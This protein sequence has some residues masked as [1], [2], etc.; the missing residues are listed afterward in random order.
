MF[1]FEAIQKTFA[2]LTPEEKSRYSHRGVAFREFLQWM[3]SAQ[4]PG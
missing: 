2:E 3:D 4:Q 1:F